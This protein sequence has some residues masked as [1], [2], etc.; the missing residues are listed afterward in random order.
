MRSSLCS[1]SLPPSV[2][3]ICYR[4]ALPFTPGLAWALALAVIAHPLHEWIKRHVKREGIAAAIAVLVV[5]VALVAP[6]IFVARQITREADARVEKISRGM[7]EGRWREAVERNPRLA[8]ALHWIEREVDVRGQ[9]ERASENILSR[10]TGFVSGSLYAVAGLLSGASGK[11]MQLLRPTRCRTFFA[12][13]DAVSVP[14]QTDD[15]ACSSMQSL[16]PPRGRSR[17]MS[18]SVVP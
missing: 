1:S 17:P 16:L 3:Y 15:E 4:L 6:M 8:P 7:A 11:S 14:R 10:I 12:V 13:D 9:V 18:R 5:T 2:F